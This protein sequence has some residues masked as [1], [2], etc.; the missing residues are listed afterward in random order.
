VIQIR[1]ALICAGVVIILLGWAGVK[2]SDNVSDTIVGSLIIV[3]GAL[4]EFG[5]ILTIVTMRSGGMIVSKDHISA[6]QMAIGDG[7]NDAPLWNLPSLNA[8]NKQHEQ[9]EH[10]DRPAL[11]RQQRQAIRSKNPRERDPFPG[12]DGS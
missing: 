9:G 12:E 5:V 3:L 2:T 6:H 11:L 8:S 1:L 4:I 10:E 7:S